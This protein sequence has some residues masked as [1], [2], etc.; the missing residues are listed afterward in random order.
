MADEEV[1]KTRLRMLRRALQSRGV[2]LSADGIPWSTV[3]AVLARGDRRLGRVLARMNEVSLSQWN[4][5]LAAEEIS[6]ADFTRALAPEE[7][8]PWSHIRLE[9]VEPLAR[10]EM[11]HP[12][13]TPV[14]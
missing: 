11:Q 10:E 6:S 8:L 3:Q 5:A 14:L 12:D 7:P 4:A 1:L 13:T 2:R 9:A